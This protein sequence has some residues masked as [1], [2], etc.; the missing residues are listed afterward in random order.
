VSVSVSDCAA[1]L[2][3]LLARF[4]SRDPFVRPR[5]LVDLHNP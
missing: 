2:F 1:F 4:G 3:D 5:K